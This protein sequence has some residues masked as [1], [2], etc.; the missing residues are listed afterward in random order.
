MRGR[1]HSR[2]RDRAAVTYHYDAGNEFYALFLGQWMAYSCAYFPTREADLDTAQAA[3]FEHICR[4]LRLRPGERLFDIG[5]GWGGLVVYAAQHYGVQA[6]GIT[7]SQPQAE[8][9]REWIQRAGLA[10]RAQIEVRDYRDL[11][12]DQPFD[13][14][15]SIGMVEHV[16]R[17]NL[18][19]YFA[20]AFRVLRP[21]GLFL[22]HGITDQ[23]NA[24]DDKV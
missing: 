23:P 13:K 7:L 18:P 5:C 22:N 12:A 16:G 17:A 8:Y 20:S 14:I 2:E 11:D 21:G 24:A 3:K 19:T 15:A 1:L 6:A 10:D 9:A 4:K